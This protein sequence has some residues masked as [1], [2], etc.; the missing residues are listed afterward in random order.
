MAPQLPTSFNEFQAM[1][2]RGMASPQAAIGQQLVSKLPGKSVVRGASRIPRGSAVY[3]PPQ[4]LGPFA[5]GPGPLP[6]YGPAIP[7][8]AGPVLSANGAIPMGAGSPALPYGLKPGINITGPTPYSAAGLPPAAGAVRLP[9]YGPSIPPAV[10]SLPG[11]IQK[12]GFGGPN[13][14]GTS[15]VSQFLRSGLTPKAAALRGAGYIGGGLA[16]ANLIDSINPF[17]YVG[18]S[19]N[20]AY[21]RFAAGAAGGA[22]IGAAIGSI[23]PIGVTTAAGAGIGALVGGGVNTIR[24]WFDDASKTAL[25]KKNQKLIDGLNPLMEK[26]GLTDAQG[27]QY[28]TQFDI[29]L[30]IMRDN[31]QDSPD[32]VS[33]LIKG[34]Q[35]Q[36]SQAAG[37]NAGK[38]TSKDIVALQAAIGQYM[39]PVI[40]QQQA[41]GDVAAQ[42]YNDMANNMG[43]SAMANLVR[44]QAAGYK[45]QADALS[46]AY[47]GAAQN[48]PASYGLQ[49]M[50]QMANQ[51]QSSKATAD[52]NTLLQQQK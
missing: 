25:S 9:V 32:N 19:K 41:S 13:A 17:E 35:A 52:F 21:D 50:A 45:A 1:V 38:F 40:Q 23:L 15:G 2:L 18:A 5:M 3:G 34:T 37:S 10:S 31:G 26:A 42:L 36:I 22:G 7:M 49:Q 8:G 43:N 33:K 24:G 44:G 6:T 20:N 16:A 29:S 12:L 46:A 47:M 11:Y 14:A 27:A 48:L 39:Q 30:Q 28:K 51:Q 4:P